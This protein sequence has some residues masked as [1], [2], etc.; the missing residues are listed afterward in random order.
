M[1]AIRCHNRGPGGLRLQEGELGRINIGLDRLPNAAIAG[2][3]PH[4][5]NGVALLPAPDDPLTGL[6]R[7]LHRA[8]MGGRIT[9]GT[10]TAGGLH[11]ESTRLRGAQMATAANLL[12]RLH[13]VASDLERTATGQSKPT[14]PEATGLAWTT[15]MRYLE[16]A[17]Q[18]ILHASW[19]DLDQAAPGTGPGSTSGLMPGKNAG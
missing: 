9:L 8:A 5:V 4:T 19:S 6:R 15:T 16:A 11:T 17:T 12:D 13:H 18:S 3:S 2:R 1:T 7:I 10:I 14:P